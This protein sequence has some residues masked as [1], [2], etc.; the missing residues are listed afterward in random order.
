[1]A[2]IRALRPKQWVK[3]G[4]LFAGILFTLD[5]GHSLA[6]WL[7]VLAGFGIFCALSSAVYLINDVCDLEQDRLH[8]K[9]RFRPLA[10]G[11][12]SV[13]VAIAA[14]TA[15]GVGGLLAAWRT[16]SGA[17]L[18]TAAA[19]LLLTIAYSLWLKHL[20][21]I[22]VMVIAAGFVLRA[23][24]GAVIIG[25]QIS[26]WLLVCTTLL[27]LFL[28]FSKRRH[29]L[30]TQPGDAVGHRRVLSEYSLELLDQLITIV[31]ASVLVA[32][33]LYTFNSPTALGRPLLMLTLPFV[34]YGIFRFLWLLHHRQ[35]GGNPTADLL[36]DW[37][38][39]L[40]VIL[41]AAASAAIILFGAAAH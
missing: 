4:F 39:L 19:Y 17:F 18:A 37:P 9:K 41:W 23:M 11:Q 27:A 1:L 22:D 7:R 33:S 10:A 3:N 24:A 31:T 30:A 8:P 34:Y 38:L 25:A 35:G 12:V 5:Q 29:E 21:L 26:P 2:L 40:T 14:A 15:L 6:D 20:V 13:P 16:G 36:E 28:G 32:Y